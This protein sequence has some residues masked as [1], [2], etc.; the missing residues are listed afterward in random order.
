M[1]QS[2][3]DDRLDDFRGEV[4]RRFDNV[5]RRFDE[6]AADVNRRFD[7]AAADVNRRFDEVDKRL[8]KL[9]DRFAEFQRTILA[10]GGGIIAT[11]VA[12]ILSL[13]G[14]AVF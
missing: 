4:N 10:T 3:T 14:I 11:L 6:A 13:I 9:D 2:W 1:R 12:G 5:D 7:K 8:D